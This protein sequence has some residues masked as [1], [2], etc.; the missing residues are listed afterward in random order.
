MVLADA[1]AWVQEF[2]W[3]E[4][5]VPQR[6]AERAE[7]AHLPAREPMFCMETALKLLYWSF[8]VRN[9]DCAVSCH[10]WHQTGRPSPVTRLVLMLP[11][12][13]SACPCAQSRQ[14]MH[15]NL[16]KQC[17]RLARCTERTLSWTSLRSPTPNL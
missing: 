9:A 4:E 7:H 15:R 17:A 2:A 3:T 6:S 12:T 1:Q 10:E 5:Q 11:L 16:L 8:L 13:D 14:C